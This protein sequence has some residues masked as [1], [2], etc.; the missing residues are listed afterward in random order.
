MAVAAATV[1]VGVGVEAG[2]VSPDTAV[3]PVAVGGMGEAAAA[4]AEA[5]MAAVGVGAREGAGWVA[6]ACADWRGCGLGSTAG[7]RPLPCKG[8]PHHINR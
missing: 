1:G 4:M 5:A 6:G 2:V 8:S 7:Q 3:I